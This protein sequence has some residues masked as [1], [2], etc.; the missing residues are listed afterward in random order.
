VR[1]PYTTLGPMS[2]DVSLPA[3]CSEMT[4]TP[5]SATAMPAPWSG[6]GSS[7]RA[8]AATT[9][10]A[11]AVAA[12]GA[13]MLIVPTARPRYNAATPTASASPASAA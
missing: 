6:S 7:P 5:A 8:I 9:G 1:A 2:R 12:T 3:G 13:T 11:G 4:A 10:T